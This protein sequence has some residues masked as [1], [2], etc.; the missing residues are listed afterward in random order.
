MP[1]SAPTY[2][3]FGDRLVKASR[4]A[5]TAYLRISTVDSRSR[6]AFRVARSGA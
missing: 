3:V 2:R 1:L 4:T 6:L 5:D